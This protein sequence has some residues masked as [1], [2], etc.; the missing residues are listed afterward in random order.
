MTKKDFDPPFKLL[1]GA[2]RGSRWNDGP[3]TAESR[4][5]RQRAYWS[6]LRDFEARDWE[7]VVDDACDQYEEFPLIADLKGMF[8]QRKGRNQY[9]GAPV[10]RIRPCDHGCGITEDT[11][12]P[13]TGPRAQ[14]AKWGPQT[15][16]E[17][18]HVLCQGDQMRARCPVCGRTAKEPITCDVIQWY[19]QQ[20]PLETKGWNP[21][22]KGLWV[23]STCTEEP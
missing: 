14:L 6:A 11:P 23:C 12:V 21:L 7:A 15:H 4:S 8:R 20:F 22:A 2:F 9:K 3:L 5:N 19:M 13:V 18:I 10:V 16:Y 1:E 17:A